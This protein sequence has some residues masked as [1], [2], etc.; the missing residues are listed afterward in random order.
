MQREKA[1]SEDQLSR[2][3]TELVAAEE[4]VARLRGENAELAAAFRAE[5]TDEG[6]ELLKRAAASLAAARDRVDAARAALTVFEK[7]GSPHGL[8]AAGGKVVGTIAVLLKPGTTQ[9]E[10][11]AALEQELGKRLDDAA[12]ELGVVLAA[13]P[14]NYTRERPGRDAEGRTVLEV[15]GRVEGDRLVPA[16]SRAAKNLKD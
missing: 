3:T 1:M 8:V 6:R 5:P 15:A 7:T 2:L 14:A 9:K 11:E 4:S 10:R 12:E 13:K 16:V